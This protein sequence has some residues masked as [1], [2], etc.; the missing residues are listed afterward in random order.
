M[1]LGKDGRE[2]VGVLFD[3]TLNP[4]KVSTEDMI[5]DLPPDMAKN[6]QEAAVTQPDMTLLDRPGARKAVELAMA[7]R[8]VLE[9][10]DL[11]GATVCGLRIVD[12]PRKQTNPPHP[13]QDGWFFVRRP[14]ALD[15]PWVTIA[16][17]AGG[18]ALICALGHDMK[19]MAQVYPAEWLT[20]LEPVDLPAAR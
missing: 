6:L 20:W 1:G 12:T 15:G 10:N 4:F 7:L 8:R 19:P 16:Y 2:L 5:A 18:L 11:A 3:P 14:D 17:H 13:S 9:E